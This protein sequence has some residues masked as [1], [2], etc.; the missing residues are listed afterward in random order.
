M[1]LSTP[2]EYKLKWCARTGRHTLELKSCWWY[3]AGVKTGVTGKGLG[4]SLINEEDVEEA[5]M[6]EG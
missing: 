3:L 4:S 2:F 6:K 1:L 5:N